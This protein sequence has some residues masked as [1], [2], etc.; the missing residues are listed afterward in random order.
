MTH[1]RAVLQLKGDVMLLPVYL[2]G[3]SPVDV[4]GWGEGGRSSKW[5]NICNIWFLLAV[6]GSDSRNLCSHLQ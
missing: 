3:Y 1:A 5:R 2:D 4:G 6:L